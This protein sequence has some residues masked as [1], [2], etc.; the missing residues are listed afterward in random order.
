MN[1][2]YQIFARCDVCGALLTTG[3]YTIDAAGDCCMMIDPCSTCLA[4][5]KEEAPEA[6]EAPRIGVIW[7]NRLDSIEMRMLQYENPVSG[8]AAM[9]KSVSSRNYDLSR[10]LD[11]SNMLIVKMQDEAADHFDSI[12]GSLKSLERKASEALSAAEEAAQRGRDLH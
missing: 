8:F 5:A 3:G 4:K 6:T 10:R 7:G 9:I 12:Y 2:Q 11:E 1:R